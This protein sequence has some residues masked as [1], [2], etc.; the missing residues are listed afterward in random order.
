MKVRNLLVAL[1]IVA[2][3]PVVAL[4]Q[5]A[6]TTTIKL[7]TGE[8]LTGQFVERG[9]NT[10]VFKSDTVGTVSVP[11]AQI[12]SVNGEAYVPT[13]EVGVFG[14][15]FL[16][17]WNRSFDLGLLG[18]S[19]GSSESIAFN[20]GIDFITGDSITDYRAAFGARYWLTT[21][22]GEK[23]QNALRAYGK[24]DKYIPSVSDRFFVFGW[25]QY[26]LDEFQSF[27]QRVSGFGGAGYDFVKTD[28]YTMSGRA[29]LG[30]TQD[31]GDSLTDD[32]RFEAMVG[33]DGKWVIDPNKQY[34]TYSSYY[35]PSLED[36]A[37]GRIVST[38]AYEA[39]IDQAKGIAIKAFTEHK[40]EFRTA[41][42]T[43][44]NNWKYGVNL[45]VKF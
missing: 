41:D 40:Y 4:A 21:S 39:V 14:S 33:V 22:D 7:K 6:S 9:K 31:F 2:S 23:S 25:A 28:D 12:D 19:G 1:A 17:G 18:Q 11:V 24:Y 13:A 26:D 27:Y 32:F 43:Q 20:T 16:A 44:H 38:I 5:P 10:A 34:L 8:S 36:F 15:D 3:A 35:F 29:G 42:D 30:A 37:D 45:V